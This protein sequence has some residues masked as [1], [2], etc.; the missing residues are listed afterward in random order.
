MKELSGKKR[1]ELKTKMAEALSDK[2]TSLSG[3]LQDI[4]I[5]DLV[6]AF[7]SR[8]SVLNMEQ[9]NLHFYV[10]DRVKVFNTTI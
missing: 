7:E 10:E 4:L 9:S 8:L 5:D 3:D 2:I 1:K 6:T